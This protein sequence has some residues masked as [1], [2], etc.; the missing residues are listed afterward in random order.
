MDYLHEG[1]LRLGFAGD[2]LA[3]LE[4]R[5]N[6]YIDELIIFNKR[7]RMIGTDDR[8]EII[9]RHILDC[10]S[11]FHFMQDHLP[12]NETDGKCFNGFDMP[13]QAMGTPPPL[14]SAYVPVEI[15]DCGSGAGLPGIPLAL[16][17]PYVHFTLIER[18][19]SRAAFLVNAVSV[20]HLS[21]AEVGQ[22]DISMPHKTHYVDII[23]CRAYS[24][25]DMESIAHYRLLAKDGALA[26][27]YKTNKEEAAAA[28]LGINAVDITP[29]HVP[30]MEDRQRCIISF[31]L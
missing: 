22:Y 1:L 29:L 16:A 18:M 23:T 15:A 17:M 4:G 31:R 25:I 3:A 27:L 9:I 14:H 7:K 6:T 10:L 21:N 13:P 2:V 5:L 20:L 30:F 28:K 19:A 26:A 11:G 12:C 24:P 8:D